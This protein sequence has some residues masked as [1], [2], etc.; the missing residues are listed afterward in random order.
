LIILVSLGFDGEA[1]ALVVVKK[2]APLAELLL[3]DLVFRAQV[4]DDLLLLAIDPACQDEE[5]KLPRLQDEVQGSPEDSR[6]IRSMR[7]GQRPVNRRKA[8][9]AVI[10]KLCSTAELDVG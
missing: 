5:Q 8:A 3:E 9:G 6:E 10:R 7:S 1:A 4:I 2:N